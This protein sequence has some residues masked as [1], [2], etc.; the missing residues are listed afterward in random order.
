MSIRVST[1]DRF[2][3]AIA[4][5][6][7]NE[8]S[9]S[10]NVSKCCPA[11][12]TRADLGVAEGT[13]VAW[14]YGDQDNYLEWENGEPFKREEVEVACECEDDSLGSCQCVTS[15]YRLVPTDAVFF[16]HDEAPVADRIVQ[17]FMFEGFDVTWNGS[18]NELI[19][20]ALRS[21]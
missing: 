13:S 6:R 10:L 4:R 16:H 3:L 7:A 19:T 20:V 9:V 12:V 21:L 2:N 8:V 15:E 18:G 17:A 14:T 1:Q 5:L 11:C